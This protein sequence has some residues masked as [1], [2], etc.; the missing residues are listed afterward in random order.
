MAFHRALFPAKRCAAEAP[1]VLDS[2]KDRRRLRFLLRHPEHFRLRLI[3]LVREPLRTVSSHKRHGRNIFR[4]ALTLNRR[5][6]YMLSQARRAAVVVRYETLLADLE[7]GLQRIMATLGLDYEPQQTD[8]QR[9]VFYNLGGNRMRKRGIGEI[10]VDDSWKRRMSLA[11]KLG[12]FVLTLPAR[13][14]AW[15]AE[16]LGPTA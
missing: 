6:L 3:L 12:V 9:G 13:A 7:Q 14:F 4:R 16:R 2:S 10:S 11:E 1:V 8:P 15:S 5:H